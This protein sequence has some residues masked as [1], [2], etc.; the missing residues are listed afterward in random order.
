MNAPR[1][2]PMGCDC[3]TCLGDG[4][5][6]TFRAPEAKDDPRNFEPFAD[7]PR[8]HDAQLAFYGGYPEIDFCSRCRD[9]TTFEHED[10]DGEDLGEWLSVCCSA[11]GINVDVEPND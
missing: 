10:E 7:A 1:E 9:H 8:T 2:H 6:D 4:E 5:T 3:S 11:P